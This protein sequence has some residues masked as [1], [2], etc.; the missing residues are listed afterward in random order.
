[1]PPLH[2]KGVD[3]LMHMIRIYSLLVAGDVF[4]LSLSM[5]AFLRVFSAIVFVLTVFEVYRSTADISAATDMAA[6]H[7]AD[8]LS[9]LRKRSIAPSKLFTTIFRDGAVYY[10]W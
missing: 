10:F 6:S 3:R 1:M 8:W 7:R 2:S 5:N 4:S 9:W